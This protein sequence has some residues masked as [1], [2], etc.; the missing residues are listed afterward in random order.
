MKS[1]PVIALAA[2]LCVGGPVVSEDQRL[3][4][5]LFLGDDGPH[6]PAARFRQLQPVFAARGIDLTYTDH[7]EALNPKTLASY[8]GLLVYANLTSITP[9]QEKA[10]IDYVEGGKGFIPVHCASYCFLNSPRYIVLVGAQFKSHGTGTFRT[11][12][13]EP[14]HPI[15]KGFRGFESWDETYVH[16]MHNDNDRIILEYRS[17]GE[18][19][20]PWTWVR[21]Q[22]KGRVFYTAWGHDERTWGNAGFQNLLERGVRWATG[23][24]PAEVAPYA[25]RPEMTAKRTDVKPFEYVDANIPFYPPGQRW[26]TIGD[27][28]KKL[29]KPLDPDESLK[30]LVTPV[31]FEVKLFASEA[32]LGGGKPI[33]M[34]WDERGRL[35]VAVTVDY[36]NDKQPVDKGRDRILVLEDTDGDGKADKTTVFADKL[37]IPT[38]LTFWQGG[39]IVQ[40]PPHTLYLKDTDGDGK[41]DVRKVLFSGWGTDDTHAGPSNLRYGPDNWI[42]GIVGYAGF[43]G[44]AGGESHKFGQGFYRF[45]PDGSK[46]EFLRSTNNNSWGVGF[47]EDGQLFGSTAN[48]N[49]SMHLPVPNR[50]YESVRGWSSSVLQ[51]IAGNAPMFPITDKVR[52]VDYHGHFTAAAGHALYTAR[53]YP[54]EYWNRTALVTEATGHLAATFVL[55]PNGSSFQSRN[56][57]N[58]LA[59]DDEWTAPVAAEVGPDGNVWVIDWYNFIVQHN[60]TPPNFKTG[61]GNAYET[62]L[63]DK[64]HGRIWRVVY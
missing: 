6:Q 7:V 47:S 44:V 57:W 35:W 13:A 64:E 10:L 40:Q 45:R 20:E 16:H 41:S 60:P 4:K 42:Y 56:A 17:E 18:R 32:Q 8:D 22:G 21:T 36:P 2:A 62:P 58:L 26:S 30:H 52:Q 55:E 31:G 34:N 27:P 46:L 50:Y 23:R 37:S 61:K 19:K 28:I 51:G 24:D 1:M 29:Q 53:T 14:D 49:P 33:C 63:R 9:Q 15:L 5:V 25:D 48:G 38:S 39:V 43:D 12:A 11:T 59:S 54:R 3:I